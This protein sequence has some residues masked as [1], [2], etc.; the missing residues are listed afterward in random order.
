MYVALYIQF[1]LSQPLV[2]SLATNC[3]VITHFMKAQGK[4]HGETPRHFAVFAD[5]TQFKPVGADYGVWTGRYIGWG[6]VASLRNWPIDLLSLAWS[7]KFLTTWACLLC[8]M[9][10]IY[11]KHTIE[12]YIGNFTSEVCPTTL[13]TKC[14]VKAEPELS[15]LVGLLE[16]PGLNSLVIKFLVHI[17][18]IELLL[19]ISTHFTFLLSNWTVHLAIW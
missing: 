14:F 7:P 19:F 12:I 17:F 2:H 8:Y 13:Q 11:A 16:F 10:A 5:S 9:K 3:T 18:M 15:I 4:P 6:M 1:H